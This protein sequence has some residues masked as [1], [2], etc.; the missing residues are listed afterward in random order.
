MFEGTNISKKKLKKNSD[1]S[2]A[3]DV[4]DKINRLNNHK[5]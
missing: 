3:I 1:A 2:F 5:H 4:G